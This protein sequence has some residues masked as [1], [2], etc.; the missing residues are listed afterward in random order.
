MAERREKEFA[1]LSPSE[2]VERKAEAA[3]HRAGV[4]DP[5]RLEKRKKSFRRNAAIYKK[6]DTS[7]NKKTLAKDVGKELAIEAGIGLATVGAGTVARAGV[8]GARALYKAHKAKKLAKAAAGAKSVAK[9]ATKG[10]SA[11]RSQAAKRQLTKQEAKDLAEDRLQGDLHSKIYASGMNAATQADGRL[12][13]AHTFY[14]VIDKLEP[15][16]L[17]FFAE[18]FLPKSIA[19]QAGTAAGHA[20][21][22]KAMA[23]VLKANRK[24]PGRWTSTPA[25]SAGAPKAAI[26]AG[27]KPTVPLAGGDKATRNISRLNKLSDTDL[28][29]G[30]VRVLGWSKGQAGSGSI[31]L[32][33]AELAKKLKGK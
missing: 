27:T 5:K 25:G 21:I 17:A 7:E 11:A 3:L 1:Y 16:K 26:R 14:S 19:D 28:R 2:K 9:I 30:A 15:K 31:K 4:H 13:R 20:I 18:Q 6:W 12:E 32:I 33:R 10:K 24:H 8:K 23:K 22:K 29:D